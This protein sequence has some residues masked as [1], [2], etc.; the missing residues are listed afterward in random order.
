LFSFGLACAEG[1]VNEQLSAD[2]LYGVPSS[3][4]DSALGGS[5]GSAGSAPVGGSSGGEVTAQ[6]GSAV[7]GVAGGSE[8]AGSGGAAGGG[9]SSGGGGSGGMGDAVGGASGGGAGMAGSAGQG[10]VGHRYVKLVATSEQM[11]HPWSSVAELNVMTTGGSVLS[12]D[13]WSVTADSE[14]ADDEQTPAAAVK[15]SDPATFWHSSWEPA[16]DQA[17]DAPLPHSLVI[18]LGASVPVTGF[19]Y[20]PRQTGANGRIKDWEFYVSKDGNTWGNPV[21]TGSFPDET[22]QQ[23]VTF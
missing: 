7:G 4:G 17:S 16:P 14:E 15:D 20:L 3:A 9:S 6:A 8:A 19:L 11:G 13:A 22:A 10:P 18:D 21:K 1:T 2:T 23:T 12:R 5:A